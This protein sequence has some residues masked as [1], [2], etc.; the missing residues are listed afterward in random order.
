M[1]AFIGAAVGRSGCSRGIPQLL[2]RE[3]LLKD[4]V[5]KGRPPC[6]SG[7]ERSPL[8]GS[9]VQMPLWGLMGARW[10]S[11]GSAMRAVSG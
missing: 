9:E 5:H 7:G 8:R 4:G 2:Q 11:D 10:D 1:L 3:G 6:N